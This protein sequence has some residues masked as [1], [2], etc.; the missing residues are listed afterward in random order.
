MK[1]SPSIINDF[2]I[3]THKKKSGSIEIIDISHALF[4]AS[5]SLHGGHVLSWQPKGHDE[6]FWLSE[7]AIYN[8]AQAIRGGIPICWPWFGPN[9][10]SAGENVG[11]HGF[12][13]INHWQLVNVE[14]TSAEVT[15]HLAFNGENKHKAWPNQFSL[16]QIIT[17]S[18][19]FKQALKMTNLSDESVNFSGAL[20]SYFSVSNPENVRVEQ[21]SNAFFDDKITGNT[22]Q[23][24]QLTHCLGPLD[25]I[26]Y[27]ENDQQLIDDKKQRKI[28]LS[29]KNCQQWVI[30]NPGVEIARTMSDI[31]PKG[32]SE[33]VCLE[34]A[35]TKWQVLGKGRSA[36]MEQIITVEKI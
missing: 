21:L 12:A 20:H 15:V 24:D 17:F 5:I 36:M 22:Q 34:A 3:I 26:Y 31:H 9:M 23:K 29:S 28:H 35:N 14:A 7:D 30:W 18:T 33:F 2:A 6:V 13:R 32:E 27:C 25:R 4:S 8:E 10:N 16:T 19:C 1:N 11:N